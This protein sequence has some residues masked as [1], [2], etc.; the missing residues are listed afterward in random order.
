MKKLLI[1]TLIISS[2]LSALSQTSNAWIQ[3][4]AEWHHKF[5]YLTKGYMRHYLDDDINIDGINF[6]QVKG[7][8]Q[9]AL[10]QPDGS[11]V[12]GTINPTIDILFF[13]SNDSVFVR[14]PNGALQF[15]WYLNPQVGDVWDFSEQYDELSE[16]TL[17]AYA[18]VQSGVQVEING[19]Q[20]ID[21]FTTPCLDELGTLP[22]ENDVYFTNVYAEQINS[23]F[24]PLKYFQNIG[25]YY[26]YPNPFQSTG[27][28]GSE[29][30]C[31]ES[32]E[33]SF[34]QAPE[35]IDCY[36]GIHSLSIDDLDELQFLVFPNPAKEQIHFSGL[37]PNQH[38][39][40][41][42][43]LGQILFQIQGAIS[44]TADV[45]GLANGLY[46][47]R[48]VDESSR[49]LYSGKFVKE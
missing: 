8:D 41:Y 1:L 3:E 21:I 34:H 19:V 45:R 39:V 31:Y 9:H 23:V 29:L 38:V 25:E 15:A 43:S 16:T 14:K 5:L 28:Y 6:Q 26:L 46:F 7:E 27:L 33:M 35:S 22:D 12:L 48:I 40:V 2:Q 24:G 10:S 17:N 36:D 4:G 20:T 32:N 18:V 49:E 42:S 11:H 13:T 47:Y 30:I 44:P 37:A